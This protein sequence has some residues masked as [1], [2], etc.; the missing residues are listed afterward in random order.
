MQ[1]TRNTYASGTLVESFNTAHERYGALSGFLKGAFSKNSSRGKAQ[2][3]DTRH[4]LMAPKPV[5]EP[6]KEQDNKKKPAHKREKEKVMTLPR[7]AR[8]QKKKAAAKKLARR[9]IKAA[10]KRRFFFFG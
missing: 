1:A 6:E 7:D 3:S 9:P 10:K 5:P 2:G 8:L 4:L